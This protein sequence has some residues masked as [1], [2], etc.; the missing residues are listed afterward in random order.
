VLQE[1]LALS[2]SQSHKTRVLFAHRVFIAGTAFGLATAM[3]GTYV[4]ADLTH[5]GLQTC[6]VHQAISAPLALLCQLFAP[7]ALSA[8]AQAACAQLTVALVRRA[9]FA[10]METQ[11]QTFVPADTFATQLYESVHALLVATSHFQAL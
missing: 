2:I 1:P 10:M 3:P 6:V 9:T 8:A 11:A 4:K 5:R 7:M